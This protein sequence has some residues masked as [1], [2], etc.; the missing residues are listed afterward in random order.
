MLKFGGGQRRIKGGDKK[1]DCGTTFHLDY[2]GR[3]F[4]STLSDNL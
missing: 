2:G 4:P 1:F 3:D